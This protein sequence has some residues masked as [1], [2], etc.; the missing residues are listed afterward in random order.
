V[1]IDFVQEQ[2]AGLT[3]YG[4]PEAPTKLGYEGQPLSEGV[5]APMLPQA[6]VAAALRSLITDEGAALP[7]APGMVNPNSALGLPPV[8]NQR[9]PRG[10]PTPSMWNRAAKGERVIPQES[11]LMSLEEITAE[12]V[13]NRAS[14]ERPP[15]DTMNKTEFW[16]QGPMVDATQAFIQRAEELKKII[17][18]KYPIDGRKQAAAALELQALEQEF[19]A[20]AKLGGMRGKSDAYGPV[21][22][23]G[24]PQLPIQKTFDPRITEA[25]LGRKKP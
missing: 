18:N 17:N 2:P 22:P 19:G 23:T 14:P 12:A 1:T 15:I 13:R 11:P 10:G 4:L 16:Q 21:Y 6:E 9:T 25:I 5:A 20:G 7:T 24:D 8:R 3:N